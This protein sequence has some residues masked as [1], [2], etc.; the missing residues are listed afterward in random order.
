MAMYWVRVTATNDGGE[1]EAQELDN[2]I[3]AMPPPGKKTHY[4]QFPDYKES[5]N[6][7]L[8]ICI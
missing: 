4:I 8:N 5:T 7:F 2:Y 6:S 3:L 1:G